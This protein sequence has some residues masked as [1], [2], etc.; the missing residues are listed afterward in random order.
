MLRMLW[1]MDSEVFE[2]SKSN[3]IDIPQEILQWHERGLVTRAGSI[4]VMDHYLSCLEANDGNEKIAV[5]LCAYAIGESSMGVGITDSVFIQDQNRHG[6]SILDRHNGDTRAVERLR[7]ALAANGY[8]LKSDDH[9]IPTVAE[10]FGD[11]RAIVNHSQ[12]LGDLRRTLESRRK[13]VDGEISITGEA[14]GPRKKKNFLHPR[15]VERIRQQKIK[16]NPDLARKD[17]RVLREQ[18]IHQHGS[19]K[20]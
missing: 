10:K 14:T 15:I 4:P 11:P 16:E 12:G 3:T 17:Q 18:I 6:R 7:K 5:Q 19:N 13:T 1:F 9:Y 8:N 2:M 20:K